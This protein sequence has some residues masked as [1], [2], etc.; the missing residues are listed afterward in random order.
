MI[1]NEEDIVYLPERKAEVRETLADITAT[2]K[3]LSWAPKFSSD[4]KCIINSY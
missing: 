2:V 1:G 4:I 3:D